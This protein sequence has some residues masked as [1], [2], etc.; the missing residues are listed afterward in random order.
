MIGAIFITDIGLI[1]EFVSAV[2]MSILCFIYPGILFLQAERKWSSV[3]EKQENKS[4]RNWA[5]FYIIFGFFMM[6]FQLTC[7]VIEIIEDAK[8]PGGHS[9]EIGHEH[10]HKSRHH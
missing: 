10:H 2:A 6:I 3:Y 8:H 7:S 4:V 9:G 1:F 5:Y